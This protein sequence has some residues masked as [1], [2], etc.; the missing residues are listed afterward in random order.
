[1]WWKQ[2]KWKVIVPVLVLAVLAA[3]FWYGGSAPDSR[4]LP[5]AQTP[6]TEQSAPAP[7]EERLPAGTAEQAEQPPEQPPEP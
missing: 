1:M 7:Q 2:K 5:S 3:A 4:G 6:Q